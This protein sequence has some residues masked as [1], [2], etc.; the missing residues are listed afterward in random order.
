MYTIYFEGLQH[1]GEIIFDTVCRNICHYQQAVFLFTKN[2]L[3]T[4]YGSQFIVTRYQHNYKILEGIKY[5][6]APRWIVFFL[7]IFENC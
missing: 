5:Y 1:S 7:K 2:G 6:W 3:V 4:F